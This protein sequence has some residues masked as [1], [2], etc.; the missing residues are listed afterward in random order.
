MSTDEKQVSLFE[1]MTSGY[2]QCTLEDD[3]HVLLSSS[4]QSERRMKLLEYR[5]IDQ[6]ARG[7]RNNFIFRGYVEVAGD[8]DP[9][10]IIPPLPGSR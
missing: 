10:A 9:M 6:E 7:R 5:S 8:D 4:A 2:G 3:V 1:I